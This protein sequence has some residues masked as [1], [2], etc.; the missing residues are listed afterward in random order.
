M[1]T[2][3]YTRTHTGAQAARTHARPCTLT[4]CA[5]HTCTH[6][7]TRRHIHTHTHTRA[8]AQCVQAHNPAYARAG[9]CAPAQLHAHTRYTHTQASRHTHTHTHARGPPERTNTQTL[10]MPTHACTHAHARVPSRGQACRSSCHS[11]L[12]LMFSFLQR[13]RR[14]RFH[15]S[16]C[17]FCLSSGAQI[18]RWYECHTA[19]VAGV[20]VSAA[21]GF[22]YL[23]TV[24]SVFV[25]A[26]SAEIKDCL[27]YTSPSPRD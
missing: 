13:A 15:S 3:A 26:R 8:R 1:H 21:K 22:P 20:L 9:T 7:Q 6:T 10:I 2:Y 25:S 12:S 24:E 4:A 27:L 18:C 16:R 23:N 5:R 11:P 17:Q 19:R 14:V